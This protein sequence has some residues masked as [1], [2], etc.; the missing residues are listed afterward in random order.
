VRKSGALRLRLHM[1]IHM[2]ACVRMCIIR[3]GTYAVNQAHAVGVFEGT[4]DHGGEAQ[5]TMTRKFVA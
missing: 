4:E 3:V 5:E 1:Q 2:Y